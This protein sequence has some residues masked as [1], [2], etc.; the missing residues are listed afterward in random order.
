M[1]QQPSNIYIPPEST[2]LSE[3]PST[4]RIGIQ[5]PGGSG[6]TASSLTFPNPLVLNLDNTDIRGLI[7]SVSALSELFKVELPRQ[8]PFYDKNFVVD[9]LGV[10]IQKCGVLETHT[11]VRKWLREEGPKLTAN[12]TAIVDSWTAL[13]DSFDAFIFHPENACYT[14]DGK[15]DFYAPWDAKIDFSMEVLTLLQN[16]KC[17]VVVLFH[18]NKERD[19]VTGKLLDKN[20]PLMQGKFVAKLK[21][22]FPYFVRQMV[23]HKVDAK[24]QPI[25]AD[26]PV[27]YLWQVKAG[28]EFDAKFIGKPDR[29]MLVDATYSSLL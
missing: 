19:K 8:L 11:A 7:K 15:V 1:T 23:T 9:K 16:L 2:S 10:K 24:L 25:N 21:N 18:E 29:P 17:N 3:S 14:S 6:K 28:P 12:Q 27:E 4:K 20:Q 13:Q 22:Y 5:G 26:G